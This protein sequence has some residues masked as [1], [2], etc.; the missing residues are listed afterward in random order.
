[1]W[2]LLCLAKWPEVVNDLEHTLQ[3]YFLGFS[4]RGT[5]LAVSMEGGGVG[6]LCLSIIASKLLGWIL[7]FFCSGPGRSCKVY[8]L[9]L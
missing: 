5:S 2:I 3:T 4:F 1:M 6:I 8:G 7:G 9:C